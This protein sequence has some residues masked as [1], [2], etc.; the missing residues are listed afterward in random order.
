MYMYMCVY[1]CMYVCMY[2]CIYAYRYMYNIYIDFC[3]RFAQAKSTAG[4]SGASQPVRLW[5][6]HASPLTTADIRAGTAW[7]CCVPVQ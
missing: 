7:A 1:V 4:G 6:T 2:V 3:L 5:R